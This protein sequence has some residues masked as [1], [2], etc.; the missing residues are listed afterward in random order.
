TPG[1][2]SWTE[3]MTTDVDGAKAFYATVFGWEI[4]EM[5]MGSGPYAVLKAGEEQIGG[6]MGMPESIPPGT[7]PHWMSYVTVND[8]D[9]VAEKVKTYGGKLLVAP[10]DI[11][12]VGRFCTFMDPQ[13]AVISA[14]TYVQEE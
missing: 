11:P 13:G 7:P 2:V 4:E 3:L 1:D 12:G 14:I 10:T 5:D 6:I 8:V 9:E